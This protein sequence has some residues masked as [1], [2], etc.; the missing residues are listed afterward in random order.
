V[1]AACMEVLNSS[2]PPVNVNI[3]DDLTASLSGGEFNEGATVGAAHRIAGIDGAFNG[4]ALGTGTDERIHLVPPLTTSSTGRCWL[5]CAEVGAR[6]TVWSLTAS[7]QY[8]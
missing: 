6:V 3:S 8:V 1:I 2:P 7:R 4:P 5:V